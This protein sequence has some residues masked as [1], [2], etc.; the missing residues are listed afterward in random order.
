MFTAGRV[1]GV[2]YAI[3]LGIGFAVRPTNELLVA[4]RAGQILAFTMSLGISAFVAYLAFKIRKF[5]L[6]LGE[7]VRIRKRRGLTKYESP[8]L[9]HVG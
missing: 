5:R 8:S 3:A 9:L 7:M 2:L 6:S 4:A 1:L